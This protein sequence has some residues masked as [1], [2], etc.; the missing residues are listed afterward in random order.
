MNFLGM[1]AHGGTDL[2]RRPRMVIGPWEHIINRDRALLGVDFGDQAII[3]W[4]GYVCRWFDHYLKGKDNGVEGDPPVFVFVM[5]RNRWRAEQD[6]PLPRTRWTRYYLHGR[7]GA[8]T[9][10]GDGVLDTTEPGDEPPDTY[11]YDP[12]HPTRSPFTGGH[13]DG[14]VDTRAS[15]GG[16]E[17]LVY[18]TPPLEEEVEVTGPIEATLF[19][20]TTARDTD[21]MV[22]LVDVRPDGSTMLLCDGVLRARC[23]D[24]ERRGAFTADSLGAIEPGRV[25]EYT[26]A[27]WRAT[28]NVFARG[29]RI[30]VEVSSSYFPYYLRNLNTGA[31]NVGLET[32]SVVARQTIRHDARHP[33]HVVLPVIPTGE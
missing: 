5:G 6:W 31:D 18:S 27:F 17:V 4:D 32:G 24:P 21:W 19:A 2:A 7:G 3:D 20:A 10:Y 12:G 22:R 23:R 14:A 28:S 9:L 8:N 25:C 33:S 13:I 30:R 26:I 15:A 11:T 1:K 29:H 16:E